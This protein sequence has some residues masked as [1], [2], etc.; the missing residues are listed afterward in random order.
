[1]SAPTPAV[2]TLIIPEMKPCSE[3]AIPRRVGK[4]SSVMSEIDGIAMANPTPKSARGMTAQGTEGG[5]A[6]AYARLADAAAA[7]NM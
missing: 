4:R 1:M 3:A 7:M 6:N 5:A 2:S